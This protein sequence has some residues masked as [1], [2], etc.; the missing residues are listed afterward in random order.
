MVRGQVSRWRGEIH[1]FADLLPRLK[2]N[3][4][5][6]LGVLRSDLPDTV[7]V[8]TKEKLAQLNGATAPDII[9]RT[10]DYIN[11]VADIFVADRPAL[12]STRR[13]CRA[14][15]RRESRKRAASGRPS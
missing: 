9:A 4:A 6:A 7:R 5:I 11:F 14:K 10:S 13:A 2:S 8:V 1:E 3:E 12:V 15:S